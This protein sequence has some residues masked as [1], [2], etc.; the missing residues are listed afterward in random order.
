M[1]YMRLLPWISGLALVAL[2]LAA[3]A[4][5]AMPS[6]DPS[7]A[8]VK[9]ENHFQGSGLSFDYPEAWVSLEKAS[10]EL[11]RS[12]IKSQGVDLIVILKTKDETCVMQVLK[13]R[14]T[15]SFD[16][17][18]QDKKQ[19][20]DKVTTESIEIMGSRFVKY[21]V[22]VIDLPVSGKAILGYAEKE[23]GDTGISYQLLS[24]GYEYNINFIYKSATRAAKDEKL[25]EQIVHT[26][27]IT[28]T[29][30]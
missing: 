23:G 7:T 16:S 14:N 27:K 30:D 26:F 9:L 12:A 15:S 29:K 4:P 3:C 28:G 10:F 22:E 17:L 1:K 6:P 8:G 19:I 5:T 18:Y 20:A 24:G 2:F 25:R 11:M 13:Q 21:T